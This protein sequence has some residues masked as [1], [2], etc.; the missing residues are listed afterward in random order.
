MPFRFVYRI[1]DIYFCAIKAARER[2][3][4]SCWVH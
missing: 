1:A 4:I 2:R 3:D